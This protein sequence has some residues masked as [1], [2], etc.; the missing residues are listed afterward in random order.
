[1]RTWD[2]FTEDLRNLSDSVR[3]YETMT[4]STSTPAAAP[5]D[6]APQKQAN[7]KQDWHYTIPTSDPR[8]QAVIKQIVALSPNH[9]LEVDCYDTLTGDPNGEFW[10]AH[11]VT[12]S[13]GGQ[14]AV[15]AI[16][17]MLIMRPDLTITALRSSGALPPA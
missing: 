7:I 6:Q 8:V 4:P 14:D 10:T 1:M 12:F 13:W 17:G 5:T 9:P 16:A 2:V 15:P 3:S 11:Y